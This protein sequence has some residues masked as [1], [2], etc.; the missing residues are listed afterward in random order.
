MKWVNPHPQEIEKPQPVE[1]AA[2][3]KDMVPKAGFK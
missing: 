2:F 1:I 3:F